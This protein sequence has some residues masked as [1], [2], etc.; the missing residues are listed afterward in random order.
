MLS[1]DLFVIR[2]PIGI[3]G[4]IHVIRRR[5]IKRI[6]LKLMPIGRVNRTSRIRWRWPISLYNIQPHTM[7]LGH[8]TRVILDRPG[9]VSRLANPRRISGCGCRDT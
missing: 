1:K 3:H 6:K 2:H 9:P 5:T 7:R 4:A 8:A